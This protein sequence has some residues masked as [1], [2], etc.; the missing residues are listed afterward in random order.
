MIK[1]NSGTLILIIVFILVFRQ[2]KK[3]GKTK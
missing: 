1:K 3:Y 2:L